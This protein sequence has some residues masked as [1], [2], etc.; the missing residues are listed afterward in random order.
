MSDVG[1]KERRKSLSS[2]LPSSSFFSPIVHDR[3]PSDD[4]HTLKKKGRRNSGFFGRN[5]SPPGRLR[6]PQRPET[7]DSESANAS[8]L[9]TPRPRGKSLLKKRTSVFGSFRSLHSLDDDEKSLA[10]S[11]ASSVDDDDGLSDSRAGIGSVVLHHGE[12]LTTGGMWRRKSQYLVLTDTHL[13]RFKNQSKAA[14]V[15][16]SIP[17][18]FARSA[19]NRQ[20]LNSMQDTQLPASSDPSAGIAL[21]CII[22]VYMLDEGR[23]SSSVEVAFVDDRTNKAAFIQMQTPDP[24]ELNL[25]MVGIRSGSELIRSADPLPYDQRSLEHVARVLEYERDYDPE[26]FR[27]FRVIQMASTRSPTRASDDMSKLSPVG[28]YLAIGWHK[29]HLIPLQKAST[30][31]SV[32]SLTDLDMASSFGLM[33]L[34]SLSMEWGDDSLHLAF[35]VPLRKPFS[36]FVAS[37]HSMEIAFWIRQQTEFLRPLWTSLPYD[38]ITPS[39]LRD[40]NS[41]APISLDEDY[42]CLDRTLVAYSASYDIDTSNIRYTIDMQ[43]DDAP[44]FKLL[45]PASPKRKRYTALELVAVMRALRYNEAFRSISFGGVNLDAIQGI[46]DNGPDPDAHLTRAGARVHIPGQENLSVLAQEVRA[47]ALKSTSLRRLDFSYSLSRVPTSDSGSHDPG[48]GIPE[49]IFPVCRRELTNVDWVVLDGIKLGDSDL[50]YLVDAASQKSSHMRALEVG[51]CGLSVHDVDLL[52]STIIAQAKTLESINISGVQGRLNP[53]VLQQYIGFFGNIKKINLSRISRTS[54]PES[55]ITPETLFNWELEELSFSQ[56]PMNRETVDAI[57]TYLASDRS[58]DLRMLRL[59]Q[60]GLSG[61][62]VAMFMHSMVTNEPRN[63]HLHVNENRVDNDCSF[64]FKAIAQNKTPTHMSMRMIDFKNEEHFRELVEALRKNRTLKYLDISKASLPYDAGPETCR[65]LQLMFE[66]NDMLEDLDISGES[67]HLDV[68]RFGIGLNQAL[69]GL[70]RNKSLKVLRIEHQKLGLQGAN[71]L[72]NVLADND[73]LREV[74]CENNDLNLQSFTVLVNGLQRNKSLLSLSGMERDRAVSLKQVRR[75]FEIAKRDSTVQISASGSIRRSLHAAMVGHTSHKLTKPPRPP[76]G[77]QF[78]L[79]NHDV[80]IVLDALGQKW[81]AEAVRLQR[82]L[83]RNCNLAHGIHDGSDDSSDGRPT[84]AKSLG[85]M[86]DS[87]K[88]EVTESQDSQPSQTT[89]PHRQENQDQSHLDI[90][91]SLD[92]E[93]E[94]QRPQTSPFSLV[95]QSSEPTPSNRLAVPVPA[96]PPSLRTKSSSIRSTRSSSSRSTGTGGTSRSS[97]G[98]AS[99]TLRGFLSGKQEGRKLDNLTGP[100]S[101][102]VSNDK[103]PQLDWSLPKLDLPDE[104]R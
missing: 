22:A 32:V 40:G 17:P 103:P 42:G 31:A 25:W 57:A 78:H 2:V 72:A 65:S 18:S 30:R 81:D 60:C 34:T 79:V 71:T 70:K 96:M 3:S 35:R 102:C 86:L 50:D 49:A 33:N 80:G 16:L 15:F 63:L 26:S 11:K 64:L 56:T 67:A 44:C 5:P 37:V 14:E 89:E 36:I 29:L 82:Y 51:N 91:R 23:P 101:V 47:L 9:E 90:F 61:Q 94:P 77:D 104:V 1:K 13:V 83:L 98:V 95:P 8:G 38:F 45:P 6:Q 20:S 73:T 27:M 75:Q 43:C 87:L 39:K 19:G 28:C 24:Q 52:L 93:P 48:C 76:P 69:T 97:Y 58:R 66:E 46:R 54:G 74:Y 4:A 62:D 88:F 85:T 12:V 100:N 53:D 55:L 99:S 21:N 92:S 59:D 41:F 84:T 7:A 68:A 10:R